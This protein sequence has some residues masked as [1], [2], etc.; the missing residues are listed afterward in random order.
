[1]LAIFVSITAIAEAARILTTIDIEVDDQA[2]QDFSSD[3]ESQGKTVDQVIEDNVK[4]MVEM[5]T[6]DKI[7]ADIGNEVE[8]AYLKND[9][10][11]LREM[12]SCIE[13]GK[14]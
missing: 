6:R 14:Q 12:K 2:Y 3:A 9:I 1:M 7:V 8:D 5:D 11:R 13:S 4:F 10:V